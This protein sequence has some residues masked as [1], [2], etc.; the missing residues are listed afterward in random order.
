MQRRRGRGGRVG[1]QAGFSLAQPS[2]VGWR[3]G[4]GMG[5]GQRGREIGERARTCR[6]RG[7]VSQNTILV[8]NA[9]PSTAARPAC[10]SDPATGEWSKHG[11]PWPALAG[12]RRDRGCALGWMGAR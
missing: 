8:G 6:V 4:N 11:S 12:E 2:V 10:Q 9:R 3:H 1:W 7:S 5:R